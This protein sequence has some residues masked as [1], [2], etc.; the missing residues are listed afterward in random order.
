VNSKRRVNTQSKKYIGKKGFVRIFLIA[1][2]V[3]V[4]YVGKSQT[5]A[6]DLILSAGKTCLEGA[7]SVCSQIALGSNAS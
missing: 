5:D 6:K 2:I 7:K 3:I 1:I 4:N